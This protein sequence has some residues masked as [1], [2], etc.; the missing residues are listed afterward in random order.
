MG[1]RKKNDQR[2]KKKKTIVKRIIIAHFGM[3]KEKKGKMGRGRKKKE[4][5]KK[6]VC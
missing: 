4:I 5:G 6:K 3:G 2:W 1:K